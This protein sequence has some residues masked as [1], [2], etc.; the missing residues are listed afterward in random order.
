MSGTLQIL[1]G[2]QIA[3]LFKAENIF[4]EKTEKNNKKIII[5][6]IFQM[7]SWNAL[8]H[9]LGLIVKSSKTETQYMCIWPWLKTMLFIYLCL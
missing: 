6:I 3:F 8:N 5:Q 4:M 9:L 1:L 2:F 7:L